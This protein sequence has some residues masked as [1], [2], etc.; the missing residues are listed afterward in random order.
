MYQLS[1]KDFL[2]EAEQPETRSERNENKELQK[3][4]KEYD[5]Q[6]KQI[7]L[8][9]FNDKIAPSDVPISLVEEYFFTYFR[10]ALTIYKVKSEEWRAYMDAKEKYELTPIK[11]LAVNEKD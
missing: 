1:G 10:A 3:K 4:A 6:M 9:L 7:V 11:D 2:K 8:E 5:G